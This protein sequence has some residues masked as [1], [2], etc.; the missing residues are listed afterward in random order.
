MTDNVFGAALEA[1]QSIPVNLD[2]LARRL[3][4]T[5]ERVPI[6]DRVSGYIEKRGDRWVIGVNSG[7]HENRQR[8][9]I[10][11]ELGHFAYHRSMLETGTNDTRAYRTDPGTRLFNA[12]IQRRHEVEA[13]RFAAALLM[14]KEHVIA[15]HQRMR[16]VNDPVSRLA[17][18]FRVSP[19]AMEIRLRDLNLPDAAQMDFAM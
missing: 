19:R 6:D 5:I 12:R 15:W 13:N 4:V 14:P 8:F 9:T 10:A 18:G 17:D 2:A 1:M 7:H 11:H 16:G 3:G